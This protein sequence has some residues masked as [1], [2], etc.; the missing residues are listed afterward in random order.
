MENAFPEDASAARGMHFPGAVGVSQC[1]VYDSEG[2]DGQRGGSP[3]VHFTCTEG[4]VVIEGSGRLETISGQGFQVH[5]LKPLNV[6]WFEPGVIHRLVNSDGL[7]LLVV[8]QNAGLPEAG[9]AVFAFPIHIVEQADAYAAAATA[10]DEQAVMRRRDLAVVGF[11]QLR[12]QPELLPRFYSAALAHVAAKLDSWEAVWLANARESTLQTQS[13]LADL[14]Q[15][16][17]TRLRA[18]R[19]Q[20]THADPT[21]PRLGMCGHLAVAETKENHD[22]H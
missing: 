2:P 21:T 3:H 18:A 16:D 20:A 17:L 19:I 22:N 7:R 15:N 14:R 4:Y 10:T 12:D 11:E 1:T 5:E 9:D 6:V 13:I 8:M